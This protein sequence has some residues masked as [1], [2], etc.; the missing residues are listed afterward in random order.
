MRALD[1]DLQTHLETGATTLAT[2][3]RVT[4]RDGLV[5]G[6]TDH[7]R[8][9]S[10][11]GT[12]FLPET[13]ATGSALSSSADLAVDNADIEGALA[14]SALSGEDL[15]AGR[16]DGAQVE[17]FRV[18]WAAVSQR[19]LLK[20][21]VIGEVKR[22]GAAFR[23]ELRG[24]SH[25]LDQP[26]GRVYQRACDVN[27]GSAKCGVD[28]DDPAFKTAGEVTALKDAQSF[29]ADGFS[30]FEDGWFAHGLLTWET[31]A[32]AGLSAHVKT[33]TQNGAVALWLPAGAA[34]EIG[35]SFT[36]TAGCD[37]RFQTC[38]EKFSNAINFRGQPFMPGNDFAISYPLKGEK[39]DGG[40]LR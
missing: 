15:A 6:F 23:A 35:D 18:N 32:N 31:G 27:L 8:A 19:V 25:T 7:D 9:L 16:Y 1:P 38:R 22:E 3:W 24:L 12:D 36:A 29:I 4:R 11:D 37:K 21:G 5:L 2:C 40:K 34:I 26:V 39:N 10:F 28:L 20:K 33:Q 13:G 14:A 30:S 17:I